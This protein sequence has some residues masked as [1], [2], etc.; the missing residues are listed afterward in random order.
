MV[1]LTRAEE[2]MLI[3]VFKQGD[4]AYGITIK[5]QLT[6]MSGKILSFGALYVSLDKL[7]KKGYL[8]K[9]VGAPTAERGG[10]SKIFYTVSTE[11]G[12]ALQ[13]AKEVTQSLW[14]GIPEA[15]FKRTQ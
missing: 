7:L 2:M 9:T 6:E 15:Q 4:N 14:D 8:N 11:G 10:R 3:A 12:N 13:K 1:V 5:K